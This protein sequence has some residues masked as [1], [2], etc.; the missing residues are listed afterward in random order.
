MMENM[1]IDIERMDIEELADESEH[2]MEVD[3]AS[4]EMDYVSDHDNDPGSIRQDEDPVIVI[5]DSSDEEREDED[6]EESRRA[7]YRES[8][9][10]PYS[11]TDTE[12]E[13][14][15]RFKN[16]NLFYI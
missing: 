1:E 16:L 6:E 4:D 9:L 3:V 11:D 10:S 2:E 7:E 8:H 14:E 13:D 5:E 12:S 15:D